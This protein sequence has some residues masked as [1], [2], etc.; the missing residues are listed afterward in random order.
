MKVQETTRE[1]QQEYPR[2]VRI[3]RWRGKTSGRAGSIIPIAYFPLLRED[4][5]SGTVNV[6][7]RMEE[8][9]KPLM[10][11]VRCKIMAHLWP[12]SADRRFSGLEQMNASYAGEVNFGGAPTPSFVKR[13]VYADDPVNQ[14]IWRKLGV[15]E[16]A[17][18][19]INMAVITAYNSI[20][21]K[22]RGAR[23]E[24]LPIRDLAEGTLARAFWMDPNRWAVVPDFDQAIM[25]G[26]VPLSGRAPISGIGVAQTISVAP[27]VVGNARE[28]GKTSTVRYDAAGPTATAAAQIQVKMT[29]NQATEAW[30]SIFAELEASGVYLSL[31][32]IEMARKTAA[33]ARIRE[34][35]EG[36]NDD[37]V[38]D[39]LMS[40]IRVPPTQLFDPIL[41]GS[42]TQVFG[43]QERHATDFAN[44]DKSLTT[45]M[46][47]FSMP[48]RTPDIGPGGVVLITC[49]I[50]PESLPELGSDH[51]LYSAFDGLFPDALE[52]TL[53]PEKVDIVFNRE[54]DAYHSAPDGVFGYQPLNF[55]W[56]RDFAR[57]GGKYWTGATPSNSEERYSFWQVR[58]TDPNLTEDFYLCPAP[59]PHDVFADTTADPFE[60]TTL[61]TMQVRGLTVFGEALSEDKGAWEE[62]YDRVDQSRVVQQAALI[63]EEEAAAKQQP[64]PGAAKGDDDAAV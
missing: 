30:P 46:V 16:R 38:I 49:E 37:F 26:E 33:F 58:P 8:T 32:N 17:G 44:L 21:N 39:L 54:V 61:A 5:I 13:G 10:N 20:V 59:F 24:H 19:S 3:D 52:D 62:V 9:V 41:L 50:V 64:A 29:S 1:V 63:M 40:G 47:N 57:F 56:N 51:F 22:R 45:G 12:F 15:H 43:L 31:A 7:V 35:Y 28:T 34:Q 6:S 55:R 4:A 25:D 60:I 11:G 36:T 14:E 42:Q 18:L 53:D 2:S 27:V 23:S 48:I